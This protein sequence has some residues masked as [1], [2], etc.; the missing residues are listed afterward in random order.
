M[1]TQTTQ[2]RFLMKPLSP[3]K[4]GLQISVGHISYVVS[5]KMDQIL[6]N[7][8]L[9]LYMDIIRVLMIFRY[10]KRDRITILNK[11]VNILEGKNKYLSLFLTTTNVYG[12]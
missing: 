9:F 8:P 1:P 4:S 11:L 3:Q 2:W 5:Q 12:I 6:V 10:N 7:C